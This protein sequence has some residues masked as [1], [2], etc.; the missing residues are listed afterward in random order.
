[1]NY[2]LKSNNF[3]NFNTLVTSVVELP[4][5]LTV[6]SIQLI[7]SLQSDE[8]GMICVLHINGSQ[9]LRCIQTEVVVTELAVCDRIPDGPF[10]CFDGVILAGTKSGEIFAF[11]LNR[12]SLMQGMWVFT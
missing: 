2:Q 7:I 10:S 8:S 12:G 1:M 3:S 5:P 11:D 9:L 6:N 4:R